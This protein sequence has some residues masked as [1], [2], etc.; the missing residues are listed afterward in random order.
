MVLPSSFLTSRWDPAK[1]RSALWPGRKRWIT[2]EVIETVNC[3]MDLRTSKVHGL[4]NEHSLASHNSCSKPR[5]TWVTK[6]VSSY[7]VEC[8]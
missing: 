2:S 7:R 6:R 1:K 5:R 3:F 4:S 8:W